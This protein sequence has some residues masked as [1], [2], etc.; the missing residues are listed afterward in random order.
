[1][2]EVGFWEIVLV[3]IVG[4]LV[5]GPERLPRVARE[6]ALWIRK[7]RSMVSSVKQEID[8]ELQVQDLRDSLNKQ[9]K[10]LGNVTLEGLAETVAHDRAAYPVES[11]PA[12]VGETPRVEDASGDD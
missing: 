1:M 10:A 5:F 3:G 6:L 12:E 8:H 2:F 11:E 9:R 7:A 4:L